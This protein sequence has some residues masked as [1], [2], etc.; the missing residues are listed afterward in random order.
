MKNTKGIACKV[1]NYHITAIAVK[2]G[3]PVSIT[4]ETEARDA[5]AAKKFA[6]D[7]LGVKASQVLVSFELVKRAF[8]IN[9]SYDALTNALSAANI[10]VAFN[11]ASDKDTEE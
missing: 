2:N 3:V 7:K 8:T 6:A 11:D 1:N 10:E 9:C 4:F 5:R